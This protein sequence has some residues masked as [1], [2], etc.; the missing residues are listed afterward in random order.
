MKYYGFQ[1]VSRVAFPDAPQP[2]LL[3]K[4]WAGDSYGECPLL[5]EAITT[6]ALHTMGSTL[7]ARQERS[8]ERLDSLSWKSRH[9]KPKLRK[10]VY[11]FRGCEIMGSKKVSWVKTQLIDLIRGRNFMGWKYTPWAAFQDAPHNLRKRPADLIRGQ[12]IMSCQMCTWV[13]K[14]GYK[15]LQRAK[16]HGLENVP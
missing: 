11:L 7:Y 6:A 12:N 13:P 3:Y 5:R 15:T 14:T 4:S 8:F 16:Y 10:L 1:N 2:G 9:A